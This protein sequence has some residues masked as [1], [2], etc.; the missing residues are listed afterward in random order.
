MIQLPAAAQRVADAAHALGLEIAIQVM[1]GGT[2]TAEQAAAACGCDVAQIVKSLVFRESATGTPLLLLV[3]GRHRVD[4]ATAAEQT[5]RAIERPDAAFVRACTGFAIGG[6]PP[7]GH[8]TAMP[9]FLD[10][11]LLGFDQVW[12]AAGTP[13]TL[14]SIDPRALHRLT[15]A[16]VIRVTA[17]AE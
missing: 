12:A 16:A 8:A 14:F 1:E 9:T 3:S 4:E 10:L 11:T 5:G 15:G 2:R 13:T 7:F 6:I 17:E